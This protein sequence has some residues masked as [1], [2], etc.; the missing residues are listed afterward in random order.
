MATVPPWASLP[1]YSLPWRFLRAGTWAFIGMGTL[2]EA[3]LVL[4]NVTPRPLCP[5]AIGSVYMLWSDRT[6]LGA[7]LTLDLILGTAVSEFHHRASKGSD[8]QSLNTKSPVT[9]ER[10]LAV[11]VTARFC[12]PILGCRQAHRLSGALMWLCA[13]VDQI[14]PSWPHS[15]IL[16]VALWSNLQRSPFPVL[17]WVLQLCSFSGRYSIFLW[18]R[19]V[20]KEIY[21]KQRKTYPHLIYFCLHPRRLSS[22]HSSSRDIVLLIVSWYHVFLLRSS[23]I[24]IYCLASSDPFQTCPQVHRSPHTCSFPSIFL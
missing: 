6:I 22:W 11:T 3:L 21:S 7:F 16:P 19:R 15:L 23:V 18:K 10:T 4:T 17:S 12:F 9:S 13:H 8:A 2:L 14:T 24:F 20:C 1:F 5:W